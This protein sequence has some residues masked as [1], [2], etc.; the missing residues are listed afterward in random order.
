MMAWCTCM[1][2]FYISPWVIRNHKLAQTMLVVETF[3]FEVSLFFFCFPVTPVA[4]AV[5]A[6]TLKEPT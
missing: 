2:S 5:H 4:T 6:R 1:C 3:E